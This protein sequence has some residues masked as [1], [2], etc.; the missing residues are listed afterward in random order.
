MP[1]PTSGD[2]PR[3]KLITLMPPGMADKRIVEGEKEGDQ[4]EKDQEE[5]QSDRQISCSDD[6]SKA[7]DSDS[8]ENYQLA[9][10]WDAFHGRASCAR[11]S[12]DMRG[13]PHTLTDVQ[14][15]TQIFED[16][17]DFRVPWR[18][19]WRR[20]RT[21]LETRI[22]LMPYSRPHIVWEILGCLML[23]YDIT[24]V[25]LAIFEPGETHF[26]DIMTWMVRVFWSLDICI[27]DRLR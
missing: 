3:P 18:D 14:K 17:G 12:C 9:D 25:P 2:I 4:E 19:T 16:S 27:P 10:A 6:G 5:S 23:L 7:E 13:L 11:R 8:E 21:F 20:F 22:L 15:G 24:V 26:T 1:A